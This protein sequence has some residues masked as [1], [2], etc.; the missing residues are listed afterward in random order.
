MTFDTETER[1]KGKKDVE[2][3]PGSWGNIA[4]WSLQVAT[5]VYLLYT[6][7]TAIN[8][9]LSLDCSRYDLGNPTQHITNWGAGKVQGK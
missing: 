2:K 7:I 4:R 3:T 9:G 6:S 8:D 5:S 1:V